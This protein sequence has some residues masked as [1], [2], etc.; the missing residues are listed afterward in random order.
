MLIAVTQDQMC[1]FLC[2]F[3]V[4]PTGQDT[5]YTKLVNNHVRQ[6]KAR[7][8]KTNCQQLN[9]EEHFII[10]CQNQMLKIHKTEQ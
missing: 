5:V 8:T 7:K 1:H 3:P 4:R 6:T 9:R 2:T 10:F